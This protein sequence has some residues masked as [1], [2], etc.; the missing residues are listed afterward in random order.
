MI[1]GVIATICVLARPSHIAMN[2]HA[3]RST[4]EVVMILKSGTVRV[5]LLLLVGT[6][7]VAPA[8]TTV[9]GTPGRPGGVWGRSATIHGEVRGVDTRRDR[10]YVSEGRGG[11]G[12]TY[13]VHYDRRTRVYDG[14]RSYPV[15]ALR[16]G[17][18]VRIR[19]EY[20]RRG[21]AWADRVDLRRGRGWS[22]RGP[23]NNGRHADVWRTDRWSGRV[24]VVDAR[25][26]YFTLDR[27]SSRVVV[28]RVPS[29][30]RDLGRRL[31]RLRRGEK[32]TIEVRHRGG[33][34]VQLVRFR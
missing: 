6:L 33:Q 2:T 3:C 14:R 4:T 32:V 1:S 16:R 12:R 25:R 18:D 7:G 19:V 26:N 30:N 28:V 24:V 10:I 23:W 21:R 20:D 8:C 22:D 5:G 13:T 31:G 9:A 17:D 29:S 11:R 27:G 34:D 15:S